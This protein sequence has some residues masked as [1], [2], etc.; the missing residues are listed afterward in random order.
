MNYVMILSATQTA[1]HD[2]KIIGD[3]E[4]M[5][6]EVVMRHEYVPGKIMK[7]VMASVLTQIRTSYLL[8][9]SHKCYYLSTGWSQVVSPTHT[10]TLDALPP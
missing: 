4:S 1:W 9:T 3:L 7:T 6:I 8:N 2:R 10:H 5:W